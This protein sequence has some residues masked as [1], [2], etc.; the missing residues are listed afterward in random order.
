MNSKTIKIGNMCCSRCIKAVK[1]VFSDLGL[2]YKKVELGFAEFYPDK[3][4]SLSKIEKA[5]RDVDFEIIKELDEEI[6]DKIKIA[7]HKLFTPPEKLDL[8]EF[9]LKTYLEKQIAAPYKKIS[10]IFSLKNKKTI[11]AYFILHKIEKAKELIEETNLSF[12][13]IAFK[14]GYKSPSYLSR[15]F[16]NSEGI[17]MQIYKAKPNKNRKFIDEL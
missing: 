1:E 5:L 17:S 8:S 7:I 14:L 10:E 9:N 11:E 3:K 2:N 6:S 12:S 4:I 16:K 13:E 15:Q